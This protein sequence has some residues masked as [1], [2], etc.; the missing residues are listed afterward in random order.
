MR[1]LH[2]ACRILTLSLL[3]EQVGIKS[4]SFLRSVKAVSRHHGFKPTILHITRKKISDHSM[5]EFTKE[6]SELILSVNQTEYIS[7]LSAIL[8][9][10]CGGCI[11]A[12]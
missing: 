5:S 8:H 3:L 11:K 7:K 10:N 12:A 1:G 6:T 2:H 9:K 4:C